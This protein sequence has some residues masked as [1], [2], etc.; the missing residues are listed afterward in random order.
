MDP[1]SNLV[2]KPGLSGV[3]VGPYN[4]LLEANGRH[5]K[6]DGRGHLSEIHD[7]GTGQVTRYHYDVRDMLTLI[8]T[9][10]F[11]GTEWINDVEPWAATYDALGR[12]LSSGRGD[13]RCRFYWRDHQLIAEVTATGK[14]RIYMYASEKAWVPLSFVDYAAVDAA[15]DS[16]KSYS[17]FGDHLGTPICVEDETGAVVWQ[18]RRIDPF[19]EVELEPGNCVDLNLRWPGHYRDPDTGLF[20][21]RYRYYDP[22]LG[23]YLQTDPIGQSG[24]INV[25]AYVPNPLRDVDLIGLHGDPKA[26]RSG[27]D[28]SGG[29]KGKGPAKAKAKGKGKKAAQPRN[30]DGT[31]GKKPPG[32]TGRKPNERVATKTPRSTDAKLSKNNKNVKDRKAAK[33]QEEAARQKGDKQ[34]EKD[35]KQDANKATEKIGADAADASVK[36]DY[37]DA[38]KIHSGEGPNTFDAVHERPDDAGPPKYIVSEAKG[39]TATNSGGRD[40]DGVQA[41]QGT[42]EYRDSVTNDMANSKDPETKKVGKK[43]QEADPDDIEYREVK[44]PL[45]SDGNPLPM[46]VSEYGPSEPAS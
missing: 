10:R 30:A 4:T 16:G 44:Q 46:K 24:G 31:F 5:F 12:R 32:T 41:Q 20:Y 26:G 13:K 39:G 45:D 36:S 17:I 14:L 18:A 3:V 11:D 37:P 38:K 27:K 8:E 15:P 1:A 6:Y 2:G 43:L 29:P 40:A 33:K 21:N 7:P 34:A 35:A 19:G 25:Y 23:R 42:P 28:K 9:G 22:A